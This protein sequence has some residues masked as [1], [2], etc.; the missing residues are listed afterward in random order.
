MSF[1]I[2]DKVIAALIQAEKHNSNLM[3]KP[4]VILWPDPEYIWSEIIPVLQETRDNLF[5]YGSYEPEKNQGPSIWIKCMVAKSLP[6]ATWSSRSVP[7][8]Y[9]PGISKNEL[10]NVEEIGFQL[11]PIIEYQYT[12]TMFLQDNGKEW[13]AM[14]FIE[15]QNNGLGIK[16]NKDSATKEALR[17]A[18]PTLFQ[19]K[20]IFKGKSYIDADFL[21]N[22]LFPDIISSIL[23]WMCSGDAFLE[24]LD[25]GKREVFANICKA[26][27]DFVPDYKNIKAIAEKLGTQ[28]NGWNGVWQ[29]Y[30]TAPHKFSEIE[31]LLRLAKPDDLGSGMFALPEESWPQVNEQKEEELRS[32]L[33]K[34]VSLDVKKASIE[35]SR[36]EQEHNIRRNW[37]W[38]ELGKAPLLKAL[39][40]LA[41]MAEGATAAFPSASI[42]EI[43][44]YYISVGFKIDFAM[45]YAFAAMK[46]DKDKT[47]IKKLIQH[48]YKPW[49]E[50]INLKFQA[51]VAIE[52]IVFTKQQAVSEQEDYV[53]FVDAFRYE[54]AIEFIDILSKLNYKITL[55][56]SWSAI[57]SL[58]PTAK[59]SISPIA[60][61]VNTQ[62]AINEFRPQLKTGKDLQRNE[63]RKALKEQNFSHVCSIAD[64]SPEL[65]CWEEIGDIDTKGHTEQADMVKSIPSLFEQVQESIDLAFEK[66]VKKIK[67]V[68]DHGWLLLPGGLPKTT[69]NAGLTETRWGRCALIKE[70][71]S[72]EFLHLP[73]RWNPAIFI[74]YAPG[75][76][77]FKINEE[78]AHG[79]IS[80]QE[81]LTP[82]LYIENS[83]TSTSNAKITSVKWVNLK[84][85]VTTENTDDSYYLDIRSKYSD[86]STSV[87]ENKN[88][89]IK[90]NKV[91]V[92]ATDETEAQAAT[93][94]LM[95]GNGRIL[96]KKV[97]TVGE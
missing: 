84:C 54:L 78:Y 35:I 72:T 52:S 90:D 47:L 8:I 12:G 63:F 44:E 18:L 1:S 42:N 9:L 50:N 36:L 45:R 49:L 4:E 62:S 56:N 55:E 76:S 16:I 21:N 75:I 41:N 64:I 33:E 29:L 80:I 57:P 39:S 59:P 26:Q 82:I 20:E 5:V 6:E 40:H 30:A 97:T 69:I 3:T 24:T 86:E 85:T 77:F 96:D 81:C 23:K 58:T 22:Q 32:K 14:A 37:I 38:Y 48:I 11:Q 34:M 13:T 79:G 91:F 95:N 88:K 92:M 28:K 94:V 73:W 25:P 19:D 68:T 60:P 71:I 31:D 10:K 46:T 65:K 67:I 7:I 51:L 66:G 27:Y 70:G 93:I 61:L 89:L 74:A 87:L 43:K 2:Y 53:L 83:N 17:K 15:N